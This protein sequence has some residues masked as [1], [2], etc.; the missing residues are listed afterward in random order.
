M[1]FEELLA[2]V[3]DEPLFESSLL[4]AGAV[5]PA[6]VRRQ[7]ARWVRSGRLYSLRRG[8][9][10]LAPPFQKRRPHPFL[11]ANQLAHGSYVSC[12][13]ALA[14]YEL[15][16]EHVPITVSVTGR[17]PRR[18]DTPLGSFEFRHLRRDLVCGFHLVDLGNGQKAFIAKP[19]KALLDLIYLHPGSDSIDYLGELRLQNLEQLD[20]EELQRWA[21]RFDRPKLRRAVA[22]VAQLA[23]TAREE[24]QTL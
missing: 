19:E 9:Y 13:S 1:K 23:R 18:W 3:G 22:W 17:R 10:A 20:L 21:Q 6:D 8:L 16:P 2:I 4:L 11:I 24:Y 14:Y 5:D 12:Q 15:I 7:L